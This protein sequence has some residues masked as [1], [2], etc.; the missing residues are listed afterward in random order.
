M[1]DISFLNLSAAYK[2]LESELEVAILRASRSGKYILGEELHLF[3]KEFS[4]YLGVNY[5]AGVGNGLDA[6]KIALLA[7]GVRSGD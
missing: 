2:E 3:E 7:V 4:E 6:I 1:A 5:C